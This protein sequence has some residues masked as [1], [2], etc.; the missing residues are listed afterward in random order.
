MRRFLL[1][2]LAV[3]AGLGV[4]VSVA[5]TVATF[6]RPRPVPGAVYLLITVLPLLIVGQ[7]YATLSIRA[8]RIAEIRRAEPVSRQGRVRPLRDPRRVFFGDLRRDVATVL[9]ML[10]GLGVLAALT[11]YPVISEGGP[12]GGGPGCPYRLRTSTEQICVSE[13]EYGRAGAAEQRVI[14]GVLIGLLS[15]HMGVALSALQHGRE[16]QASA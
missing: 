10:A 12:D 8:R 4:V 2:M 14:A 11:A 1:W 13:P 6:V 3:C 15:V 5:I 7:V 16:G 9:V